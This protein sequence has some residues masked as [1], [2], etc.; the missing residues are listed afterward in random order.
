MLL[1]WAGWIFQKHF[2]PFIKIGRIMDMLEHFF[3]YMLE[4]W[5]THAFEGGL[6]T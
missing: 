5:Q 3:V 6:K 4:V 2:R 1:Y